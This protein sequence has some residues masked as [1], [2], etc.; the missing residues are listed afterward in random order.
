MVAVATSPPMQDYEEYRRTVKQ[1]DYCDCAQ[2]DESILQE[3]LK[4]A[5]LRFSRPMPAGLSA[6]DLCTALISFVDDYSGPYPARAFQS[7]AV[8]QSFGLLR[9]AAE[10]LGIADIVRWQTPA[11]CE[12]ALDALLVAHALLRQL[13]RGRDSRALPGCNLSLAE[14]MELA[15]KIAPFAPELSRGGDPPGD[16]YHYTANLCV[17][18]ASGFWRSSALW[19]RPLFAAGPWLMTLIRQELFGS[20]LFFGNHAR[21]DWLG[22]R[23]GARLA[24]AWI[25]ARS[26]GSALPG[27]ITT[28][29][30]ER[31]N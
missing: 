25:A 10:P 27:S 5:L 7:A 22:L 14:R 3:Q 2:P 12:S 31:A 21:I 19:L 23:H 26:D 4:I 8:E 13:A 28:D 24:Q 20:V 11:F 15:R 17:G 29:A 9:G 6:R 18:F 16:A 1:I 30:S